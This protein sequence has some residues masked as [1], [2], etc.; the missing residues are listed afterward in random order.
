MALDVTPT[1]TVEAVL[2]PHDA[3]LRFAASFRHFREWRV[4]A[5]ENYD[6]VEG[7]QWDRETLDKLNREGRPALTINKVLAQILALDGLMRM[8]RMRIQAVPRGAQDTEAAH[9]ISS[10]IEFVENVSNSEYE[11]AQAFTDGLTAGLGVLEVVRTFG[12]D[13]EDDILIRAVDP[14]QVFPDPESRRADWSDASFV[15]KAPFK[16]PDE[17]A[18]LFPDKAERVFVMAQAMRSTDWLV[19]PGVDSSLTGD[20]RHEIATE[21]IDPETRK[22]RVLEVYYRVF[23][24]E[25]VVVA[26]DGTVIRTPDPERTRRTTGGRIERRPVPEWR[27]ATVL[28]WEILQDVKVPF[29]GLPLVPYM[30]LYIRRYP[31]G[32]VRHFKDP[33]RELNKRRSQTLHHI[34]VSAHSGWLNHASEG[35]D[36]RVLEL[37]GSKPGVVI[38]YASVKPEQ[39]Q[40]HALP[41]GLLQLEALADRDLKEIGVQAELLGIGT[42]RFI[43]GRAIQARQFGG[44]IQISRYFDQFRLTRKLLGRLLVDAVTS[45]FSERKIREIVEMV[46]VRGNKPEFN[47]LLDLAEARAEANGEPD[48]VSALLSRARSLRYD[49]VIDESDFTTTQRQAAFQQLLQIATLFPGAIDA[50]T[51]IEFSDVK[52]KDE[53][54]ARLQPAMPDLRRMANRNIERLDVGDMAD[55]I[56]TILGAGNQGRTPEAG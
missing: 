40:P 54:I 8:N 11:E 5:L 31:Y 17:L 44:Q 16:A 21:F 46:R 33:Q 4:E 20:M 51:L 45:I 9:L 6:F 15:I 47:E 52:N 41:A 30:P 56:G 34:N 53:L 49:I 24:R 26:P 25:A 1:P 28:G 23:R 29:S 22:V 7:K 13:L 55:Q 14:L 36:P 18:S 42:Q 12:P 27:I 35:A 43:S 48:G 2:A 3:I 38:N 39:I 19:G 10:L 37:Y 32:V 50:K